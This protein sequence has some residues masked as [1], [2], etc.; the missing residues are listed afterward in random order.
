MNIL[1]LLLALFS[2]PLELEN[3]ARAQAIGGL[4]RCPV[5]QGM[6]IA[7]SPAPMA[8]DMMGQVR[9]MVQEKKSDE[10]IITYF[11]DRYGDWVR[12]APKKEGFTL[13]VWILPPLM[14]L[15]ALA[16]FWRRVKWSP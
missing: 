3:E 10:A 9:T 8:R 6:P 1:L 12:L 7:E 16:I 14:A 4:L 5:C 15:V 2:T 11:T 13:W